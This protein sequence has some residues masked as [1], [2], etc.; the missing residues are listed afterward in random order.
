MLAEAL[1]P[2]ARPS[3]EWGGGGLKAVWVRIIIRSSTS[4]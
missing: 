4:P 3:E 2:E 1:G